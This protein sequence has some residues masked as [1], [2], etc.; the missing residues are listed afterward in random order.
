MFHSCY[1]IKRAGIKLQ[2]SIDKG[3]N[4]QSAWDGHVGMDLKEA[5]MAHAYFWLFEN[6]QTKILTATK[7]EKVRQVL[8]RL[9][10]LYGIEKILSR[11]GNYFS[12]GVL[13]GRSIKIFQ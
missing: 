1:S 8:T 10:L 5:G 13:T 7:N 6:F 2:S 9:L 3:E 4:P 11:S 12:T